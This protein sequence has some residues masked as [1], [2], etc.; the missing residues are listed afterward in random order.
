MQEKTSFST[1]NYHEGKIKVLTATPSE[2]REAFLAD[3]DPIDEYYVFVNKS[4]E[5]EIFSAKYRISDGTFNA[6]NG[7]YYFVVPSFHLPAPGVVLSDELMGDVI[8]L[9]RHYWKTDRK[10]LVIFDAEEKII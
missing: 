10:G 2:I 6:K 9:I 3:I 1:I 7:K 8:T 4:E 5:V